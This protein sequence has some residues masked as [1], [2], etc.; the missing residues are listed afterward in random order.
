MRPAARRPRWERIAKG[1][2]AGKWQLVAPWET[3]FVDGTG[4]HGLLGQVTGR[5]STDVI[6][7]LEQRSE[8]WRAAVQIV[9]ID[10]AAPYAL[11]VRSALPHA[12]LA[13]D[14][15]HLVALAN[16]AVTAVRQRIIRTGLSRRGRKTDPLWANRRR[17]LRGRE[18]LRPA[19]LARLWNDLADHDPSAELAAAWI[20]KEQLRALLAC[21]ARGG[22]RSD[23]AH[24]LHA[25]YAW[26]A[27]VDVPEVTTLAET[28]QTWWPEILVFLTTGATNARTEGTNTRIKHVKRAA[29]GFRNLDNYRDRVRLHCTRRHRRVPARNRAL[30]AQS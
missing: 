29:A 24:H 30:P 22:V 26:C 27:R 17:L 28:V 19:T 5:T 13:V 1:P 23:I 12:Q 7:W 20:A 14:H 9:T 6:G 10:P 11:A 4:A 18:R 16:R 2:R 25:F 8:A 21:A 15:F 3:G